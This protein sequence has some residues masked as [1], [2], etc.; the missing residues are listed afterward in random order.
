[1]LLVDWPKASGSA[2]HIA[3][4][5]L[6]TG[7]PAGWRYRAASRSAGNA[8]PQHLSSLKR[9]SKRA[10]ERHDFCGR[11]AN[12]VCELFIVCDQVVEVDFEDILLG[13]QVAA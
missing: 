7:S 1:M 12:P 5:Q 13:K 3:V 2:L 8:F 10:Y 4:T 9:S 11:L 6:R